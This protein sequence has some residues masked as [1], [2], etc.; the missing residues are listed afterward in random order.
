MKIGKKERKQ[1]ILEDRGRFFR[2]ADVYFIKNNKGLTQTQV[3]ELEEARQAWRDVT[4]IQG[5]P[6]IDYD[7]LLLT[8]TWM[9][10][11]N[12]AS[13]WTLEDVKLQEEYVDGQSSDV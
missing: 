7:P 6:D 13:N 4:K 11:V 5:F 2:A 8:P 1:A 10:N 12:Y 3:A 9:E